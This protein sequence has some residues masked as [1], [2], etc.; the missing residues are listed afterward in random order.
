[1]IELVQEKR[2]YFN[3]FPPYQYFIIDYFISFFSIHILLKFTH[4][5]I[6][7]YDYIEAL[8]QSVNKNKT[9]FYQ[10]SNIY[11]YVFLKKE[12]NT[13]TDKK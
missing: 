6:Y 2:T 9:L 13:L 12:I 8:H 3:S 7:I 11:F 4:T 10:M 1:M 5:H